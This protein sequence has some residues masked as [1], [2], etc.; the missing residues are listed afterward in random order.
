MSTSLLCGRLSS[1]CILASEPNRIVELIS[2]MSPKYVV[3]EVL[4]AFF[5]LGFTI[6]KV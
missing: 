6:V 1:T 2:G 5:F 3:E 4:C